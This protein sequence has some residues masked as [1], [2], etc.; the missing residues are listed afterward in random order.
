[1]SL[2]SDVGWPI[3]STMLVLPSGF[4]NVPAC[5]PYSSHR[6]WSGCF[7]ALIL[8]CTL[9][10]L[11]LKPVPFMIRIKKF[12]KYSLALDQLIALISDATITPHR[13]EKRKKKFRPCR[14]VNPPNTKDGIFRYLRWMTIASNMHFNLSL[15]FFLSVSEQKRFISRQ[16]SYLQGWLSGLHNPA[17][18]KEKKAVSNHR[19]SSM[20][21]WYLVLV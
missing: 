19:W 16:A 10:W 9:S 13:Q 11:R 17:L 15:F 3:F 5:S 8:Q 18:T 21:G 12:D 20:H 14:S 7:N 4:W 1:M 2:L 6:H